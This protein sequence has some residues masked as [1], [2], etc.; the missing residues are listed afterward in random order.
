VEYYGLY[1]F[2]RWIWIKKIASEYHWI[3][4]LHHCWNAVLSVLLVAIVA[5]DLEAIC[6]YGE[7]L[8]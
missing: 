5:G 2:D 1:C 3:D 7:Y 8:L 4:Y 6:Q